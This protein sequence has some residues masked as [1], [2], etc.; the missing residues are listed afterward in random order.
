[1]SWFRHE[2][3]LNLL[4]GAS[5]T[6]EEQLIKDQQVVSICFLLDFPSLLCDE[7]LAF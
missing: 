1:M 4:K 6:E 2:N 5:A 7:Q 3:D